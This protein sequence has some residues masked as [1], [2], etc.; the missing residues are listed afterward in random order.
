MLEALSRLEAATEA[1]AARAAADPAEVGAAATDYLRFFA[2]V[3]LGW[4]WARMALLPSAP[5]PSRPWRA[6]SWRGYCRRRW[7]WN[8]P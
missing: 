1:L 8:W 4:M 7:R 2:L 3:A 5:R 6:S